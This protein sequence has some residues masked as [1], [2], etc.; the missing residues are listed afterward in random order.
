MWSPASLSSIV[1]AIAV[2]AFAICIGARPSALDGVTASAVAP[3]LITGVG[4]EDVTM[5][6]N[7]ANTANGFSAEPSAVPVSVA[8]PGPVPGGSDP[9]PGIAVSTRATPGAASSRYLRTKSAHGNGGCA[10]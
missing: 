1:R 3:R 5:I 10:G 4:I 9:L 7:S 2:P 8:P 6:S